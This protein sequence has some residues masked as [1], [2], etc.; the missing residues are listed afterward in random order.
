MWEE[1]DN[2][3]LLQAH[4]NNTHMVETYKSCECDIEFKGIAVMK[5]PY[6]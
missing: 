5:K 6:K 2:K 3:K 4:M 1:C